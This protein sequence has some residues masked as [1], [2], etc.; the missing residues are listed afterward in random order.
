[1][2]KF[3]FSKLGWTFGEHRGSGRPAKVPIK[4]AWLSQGDT[5][6][7]QFKAPFLPVI[8]SIT[9]PTTVPTTTNEAT[10]STNEADAST[11]IPTTLTN[12][13]KKRG[14]PKD[15]DEVKASK[16][17]TKATK[18]AAKEIQRIKFRI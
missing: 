6:I 3:Y 13:P 16:K 18:K 12:E 1:M 15:T 8:E 11:N 14:R 5:F 4:S 2:P 7:S 10:T 9:T 17:E